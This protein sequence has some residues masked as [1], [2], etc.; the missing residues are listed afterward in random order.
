[1]KLVDSDHLLMLASDDKNILLNIVKD[2]EIDALRIISEC[3]TDVARN[4]LK[5]CKT[6][7]H[8]LKGSSGSLG[9]TICHEHCVKLESATSC[10]TFSDELQKLDKIIDDSVK[11]A[12]EL[13]S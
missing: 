9:L 10:D 1:M 7:I 5:A 12:I 3:Q 13:L 4:D 8:S 6:L 2:F 11:I